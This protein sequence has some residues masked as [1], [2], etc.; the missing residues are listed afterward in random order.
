MQAVARATVAISE[1]DM[2]NVIFVPT[3]D[4][5][6]LPVY[7]K[8]FQRL[9]IPY[10]LD[11]ANMIIASETG[12]GKTLVFLMAIFLN[13]FPQTPDAC[14]GDSRKG[15]RAVL[16]VPT[17]SRQLVQQHECTFNRVANH[18][19]NLKDCFWET[20]NLVDQR[21]SK[22][23]RMTKLGVASTHFRPPQKKGPIGQTFVPRSSASG[24][25]A[26]VVGA[27]GAAMDENRDDTHDDFSQALIR[28]DTA[29]RIM[30]G[31][32]KQPGMFGKV[33]V[34]AM[35]EV[36]KI[37]ADLKDKEEVEKLV[38][39]CK[40]SQILSASATIVRHFEQKPDPP[41]Q[42]LKDVKFSTLLPDGVPRSLI[43]LQTENVM[44][45][46]V[47]HLIVDLRKLKQ[48]DHDRVQLAW[49]GMHILQN[50]VSAA[51]F[52]IPCML[53]WN[54]SKTMKDHCQKLEASYEDRR[55]GHK[56]KPQ[57]VELEREKSVVSKARDLEALSQGQCTGAIGNKVYATGID[58]P[59]RSVIISNYSARH[60]SSDYSWDKY[61][62]TSGRCGRT[63]NQLGISVIF[64]HNEVRFACCLR[65]PL[66][67]HHTAPLSGRFSTLG[68]RV[69]GASKQAAFPLRS[70]R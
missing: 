31:Y 47:F 23:G 5:T 14:T 35:D 70:N 64:I 6:K 12:S 48:D 3:K 21:D 44:P 43:S 45:S 39:I 19:V 60:L 29:N 67:P 41:T 8:P 54:I 1:E 57:L 10:A 69:F 38:K 30:L 52:P 15:I 65:A 63:P 22:T 9:S 17:G 26:A 7:P 25:V 2:R 68:W 33:K 59:F 27:A 50:K 56:P 66:T 62:H 28:I 24:A 42:W 18:L 49:E 34:I 37:H 32:Q 16:I 58:Y 51:I 20:A 40:Y 55:S 61:T 4:P 46:S 36:D 11:G 53:F 13:A